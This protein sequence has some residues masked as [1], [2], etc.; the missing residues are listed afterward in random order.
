MKRLLSMVLSLSRGTVLL[1][2][3]L[4]VHWNDRGEA[5]RR[6]APGTDTLEQPLYLYMYVTLSLLELQSSWIVTITRP[7]PSAAAVIE[8]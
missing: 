2:S 8:E 5:T 3:S 4:T 6:L 7:H 1:M